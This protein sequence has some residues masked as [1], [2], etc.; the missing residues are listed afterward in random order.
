M[1]KFVFKLGFSHTRFPDTYLTDIHFQKFLNCENL[2]V[3]DSK[4]DKVKLAAIE[5]ATITN[6]EVITMHNM[7]ASWIEEKEVMVRLMRG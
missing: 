5:Q 4:E 3:D 7:S 1:K 6:N 2:K